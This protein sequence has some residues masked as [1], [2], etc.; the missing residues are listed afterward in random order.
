MMTALSTAHPAYGLEGPS[1]GRTVD[2]ATPQGSTYISVEIL[3]NQTGPA[4]LPK[5][6]D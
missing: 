1:A 6:S 2:I 4:L 3:S 5:F